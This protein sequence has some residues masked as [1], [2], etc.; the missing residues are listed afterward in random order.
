MCL[1]NAWFSLLVSPQSL[2]DSPLR[3]EDTPELEIGTKVYTWRLQSPSPDSR[4][5]STVFKEETEVTGPHGESPLHEQLQYG[6]S[7]EDTTIPHKMPESRDSYSESEEEIEGLPYRAPIGNQPDLIASVTEPDYSRPSV[8]RPQISAEHYEESV[9]SC[10]STGDGSDFESESDV[11]E[12]VIQSTMDEVVHNIPE[13]QQEV[14]FNIESSVQQDEDEPTEQQP[15]QFIA[16]ADV[17]QAKQPTESF[18]PQFTVETSETEPSDLLSPQFTV[19]ASEPVDFTPHYTVESTDVPEPQ[20]KDSEPAYVRRYS[21]EKSASESDYS[22]EGQSEEEVHIST[23]SI[24]TPTK[25]DTEQVFQIPPDETFKAPT[26]EDVSPEQ[27]TLDDDFTFVTKDEIPRLDLPQSSDDEENVHV[28]I[29]PKQERN[30]ESVSSSD[31]DDL[32]ISSAS[33][34]VDEQDA[35]DTKSHLPQKEPQEIRQESVSPS[36]SLS[37]SESEDDDFVK[38][39]PSHPQHTDADIESTYEMVTPLNTNRYEDLSFEATLDERDVYAPDS[40]LNTEITLEMP[41]KPQHYPVAHQSLDVQ[42]DVDDQTRDRQSLEMYKDRSPDNS[43]ILDEYIIP[44]YR[45]GKQEVA[46]EEQEPTMSDISFDADIEEHPNN[47][48]HR[49]EMEMFSFKAQV[50]DEEDTDDL[51]SD[52]T[53]EMELQKLRNKAG[54]FFIES[55]I[56]EK[57]E[58]TSDDISYELQQLPEGL[59]PSPEKGEMI[60]DEEYLSGL[61]ASPI[62]DITLPS[63]T[64]YLEEEEL[65][66]DIYESSVGVLENIPEEESSYEDSPTAD[67]AFEIRKP[68]SPQNLMDDFEEVNLRTII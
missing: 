12:A 55:E 33:S 22:D 18:M 66:G 3:H 36:S 31:V 63:D 57:L 34:E 65:Q 53:Y 21:F 20:S 14:F 41:E 17:D 19:D 6:D 43:D 26:D 32:T 1:Y 2:H 40:H 42:L 51:P 58:D 64:E 25:I 56:E 29:L 44:K 8:A 15:L 39:E 46:M 50:V 52:A 13:P 48:K 9:S 16:E 30:D 45:E 37:T 24:P 68:G 47:E 60:S 62:G 59:T 7:D 28:K 4:N 23:I 54:P 35:T 11:E 38:V 5:M 10:A 67:V 49:R 61:T 27:D